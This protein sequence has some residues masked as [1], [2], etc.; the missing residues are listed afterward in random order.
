MGGKVFVDIDC[1]LMHLGQHNYSG[2]LLESLK[3]QGRW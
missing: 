3:A 1:K 2:N